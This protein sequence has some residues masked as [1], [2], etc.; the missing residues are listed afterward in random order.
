MKYRGKARHYSLDM[1]KECI[2]FLLLAMQSKRNQREWA[3]QRNIQFFQCKSTIP[4]VQGPAE[5][6]ISHKPP[7]KTQTQKTH[8]I[9]RMSCFSSLPATPATQKP[10]PQN[11]PPTPRLN[12]HH[13]Y[14]HP[15]PH[16]HPHLHL[17]LA[18]PPKPYKLHFISFLQPWTTFY[19][20]SFSSLFFIKCQCYCYAMHANLTNSTSML[21]LSNTT[22]LP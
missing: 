4:V 21:P 7:Y 10:I 3:E 19:F 20:P 22:L 11:V 17:T 13:H 12:Q 15:H 6:H 8:P 9:K 18:A 1:N 2:F 5:P 16:P 14:S